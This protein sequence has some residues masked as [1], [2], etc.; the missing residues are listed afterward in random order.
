[1]VKTRLKRDSVKWD[2][3]G[4]DADGVC[5]RRMRTADGGRRM[6]DGGRRTTDGG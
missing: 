2:A 1:M 4:A 3:D 5:G 6:E